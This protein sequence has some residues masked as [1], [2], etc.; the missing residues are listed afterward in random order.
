[1][2]F[3]VIAQKASISIKAMCSINLYVS[4]AAWSFDHFVFTFVKLEKMGIVLVT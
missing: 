1:M 3:L 2:G 4:H